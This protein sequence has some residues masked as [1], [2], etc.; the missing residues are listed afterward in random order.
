MAR[1]ILSS[2]NKRMLWV[3]PGFAH[4][5]LTLSDTAELV[6]KCTALYSPADERVL[7]WDDPDVGIEW[8][9]ISPGRLLLSEK[10]SAGGFLD[11]VETYP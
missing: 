11:H 10:D 1:E 6:Y 4:G 9:S 3:P 7:R 8:P 5:F 2:A